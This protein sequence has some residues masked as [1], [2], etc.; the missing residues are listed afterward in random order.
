MCYVTLC[1]RRAYFYYLNFSIF[2]ENQGAAAAW[3]PPRQQHHQRWFPPPSIMPMWGDIEVKKGMYIVSR[4]HFPTKARLTVNHTHHDCC[5][6]FA[7]L[8]SVLSKSIGSIIVFSAPNH[9]TRAH[10]IERFSMAATLAPL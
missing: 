1:C 6:L 7:C 4:T 8:G 5:V 3:A 9:W 2:S 10:P